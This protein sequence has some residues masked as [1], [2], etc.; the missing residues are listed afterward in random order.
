MKDMA[1]ALAML[2]GYEG[3]IPYMYLDTRGFVTVGV[4]FWLDC[5]EN[6]ANYTFHRNHDLQKA[7]P[8]E[9][10]AEWA[11]LKCQAVNHLETYYQQFTTM[12]MMQPDIDAVLTQKLLTFETQARQTFADWD[13]F[14][15]PAQ[16]ALIDMIYN[17]GSLVAFPRLVRYATSK[18]WVR[19]AQQ[20]WRNGPGD[21]R[22]H[23]TRDRFLAAAKEQLSPVPVASGPA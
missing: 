20:C 7:T 16:L 3:C 8:A 1:G 19:C 11:H 15:A 4:G 13:D 21:Q 14:P 12:Q 2:K 18:D 5:A 23:E 10:K 9:V 22:N 17:L 6:A